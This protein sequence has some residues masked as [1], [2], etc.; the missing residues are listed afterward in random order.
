[1]LRSARKNHWAFTLVELLVVIAIIALL[2][3]ILL[4]SLGRAREQAKKMRCM[5]NMKDIST[6]SNSYSVE[7]AQNILV[8]TPRRKAV[9]PGDGFAWFWGN[10]TFGGKGGDP[11]LVDG[12]GNWKW[13]WTAAQAFGP[14]D[15][16]LNKVLY[17]DLGIQSYRGALG[18]EDPYEVDDPRIFEE[19][20]L[21]L[22]NFHCPSDV[23]LA[24]GKGVLSPFLGGPL[25]PGNADVRAD[26]PFY[27]ITGNSYMTHWS[28]PLW[29][30]PGGGLPYRGAGAI[31]RPAE[32]VPTP[33][34]CII[35]REANA[36]SVE[37]YNT[38]WS[39]D[40]AASENYRMNGWHGEDMVFNASFADGHAGPIMHL[41][42]TN[43]VDIGPTGYELIYSQ[44]HE[45]RGSRIERVVMPNNTPPGWADYLLYVRGDGWQLDFFPQPMVIVYSSG[46]ADL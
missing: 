13:A 22:A 6:A 30:N 15:R 35:Y 43:I 34:R 3:S 41:V 29:P 2:I 40:N 24:L 31:Q 18:T 8:P 19:A 11:T 21:D 10:D 9:T 12:E 20:K 38:L 16:P 5:G 4:P 1:M 44:Q 7:D 32:R 42:R 36:N 45:L 23:G 37:D 26:A 46:D 27:D 17:K 14:G 39:A 25:A 33:S 28:T